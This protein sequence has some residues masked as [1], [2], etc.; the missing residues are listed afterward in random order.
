MEAILKAEWPSIPQCMSFAPRL[1]FCSSIIAYFADLL[2]ST[3]PN[4]DDDP[5]EPLPRTK[6]VYQQNPK[7]RSIEEPPP[8]DEMRE[9]EALFQAQQGPW[10]SWYVEWDYQNNTWNWGAGWRRKGLPPVSKR[11]PTGDGQRWYWQEDPKDRKADEPLANEQML[12]EERL[13]LAKRA[14]W[15]LWYRRSQK[16]QSQENV[17]AADPIW[18]WERQWYRERIPNMPNPPS[19]PA[20]LEEPTDDSTA[21]KTV[22]SF[23]LVY[24]LVMMADW[25]QGPYVYAVLR[26]L[27][28]PERKSF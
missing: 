26:E 5:Y 23:L 21:L 24:F 14:P 7:L 10:P 17:E 25:M 2:L 9:E 27:K 18:V 13:A 4:T 22:S 1:F 16:A 3:R 6:W 15:P 19:S 8:T 20:F 28:I 11:E 12:E